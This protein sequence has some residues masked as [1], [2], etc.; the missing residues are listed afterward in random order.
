MSC[1]IT[2]LNPAT[3]TAN[4]ARLIQS[5]TFMFTGS[6]AVILEKGRAT[7]TLFLGAITLGAERDLGARALSL[8]R[9]IS[10]PPSAR[11]MRTCAHTPSGYTFP[12]GRVDTPRSQARTR[13]HRP[14]DAQPP[15]PLLSALDGDAGRE[16]AHQDDRCG[17]DKDLAETRDLML[18]AD[19]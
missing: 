4:P 7:F 8:S 19:I 3:E 5:P 12:R 18:W 10:L 11:G 15:T 1:Q 9:A 14:A 2:T 6:S 13:P 17:D 16:E